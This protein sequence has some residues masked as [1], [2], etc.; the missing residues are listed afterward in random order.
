MTTAEEVATAA[1]VMVR[2]MHASAAASRGS[3]CAFCKQPFR[4]KHR[5]NCPWEK[6]VQTLRRYE[7]DKS[8]PV[9]VS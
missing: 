2:T 8:S 4:A 1:G 9:G 6:L 5:D 3:F 7:K